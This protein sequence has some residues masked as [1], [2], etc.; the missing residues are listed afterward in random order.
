MRK[1]NK[2]E[3]L[4][5]IYNSFVGM[6]YKFSYEETQSMKYKIDDN[7]F[8]IKKSIGNIKNYEFNISKPEM[9]LIFY[10]KTS[11]IPDINLFGRDRSKYITNIRISD[12]AA[13]SSFSKEDFWVL[14]WIDDTLDIQKKIFDLIENKR[15]KNN[16]DQEDQ[17][18]N[19]YISE[20]NKSIDKVVSRDNKI[21][22]IIDNL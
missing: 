8:E 18:Y 17:K 14:S 2:K 3:L 1:E 9:S 7:I 22:D 21:D 5:T 13:Y 6:E 12:K 10:I 16:I 15:I 20:L 19:K 11:K 4:S